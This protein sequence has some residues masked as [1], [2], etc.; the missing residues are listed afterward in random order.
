MNYSNWLK[1]LP[2][3]LLIL[4]PSLHSETESKQSP[5]LEEMSTA[6]LREALK[7]S[8]AEL[9]TRLGSNSTS[10][11]SEDDTVET[12]KASSLSSKRAY[13]TSAQSQIDMLNYKIQ[14]LEFAGNKDRATAMSDAYKL[15]DIKAKAQEQL[16]KIRVDNTEGWK[17]NKRILDGFLR[18]AA[19]Y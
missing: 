11:S 10:L 15:R 1:F 12:Q 7:K 6:E 13:E 2:I 4:S 17:T 8:H 14:T 16:R 18:D 9:E 3:L 19:N 5:R